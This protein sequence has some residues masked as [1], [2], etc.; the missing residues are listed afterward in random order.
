MT[1]G[2]LHVFIVD[3]IASLIG[4]FLF[5]MRALLG[6]EVP[7]LLVVSEMLGGSA[8]TKEQCSD[9]INDVQNKSNNKKKLKHVY[10]F[11]I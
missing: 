7:L 10:L 4:W 9:L 2:L 8:S 6:I 1:E 5:L 11:G 3:V